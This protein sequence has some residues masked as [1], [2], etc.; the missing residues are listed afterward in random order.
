MR[1]RAC[2]KEV[3]EGVCEKEDVE[4]WDACDLS[5]RLCVCE[6]K[7]RWWNVRCGCMNQSVCVNVFNLYKCTL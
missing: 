1:A 3:R 7:R 4:L 5:V 2:V 6:G